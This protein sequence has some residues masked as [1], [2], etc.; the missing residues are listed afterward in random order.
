[1]NPLLLAVVGN[2]GRNEA[3]GG[4]ITTFTKD[5]N[6]WRRHTFTAS[7]TLTVLA[8]FK[9]WTVF[10]VAAGGQGGSGF[11]AEIGYSGYPGG[12][13]GGFEKIV[14]PAAVTTGANTITVGVGKTT[15]DGFGGNSVALGLTVGGGAKGGFTGCPGNAFVSTPTNGN[16]GSEGGTSNGGVGGGCTTP[17]T[18]PAASL[19]TARGLATT[20]G[21]GGA[22]TGQDSG[23]APGAIGGTGIVIVEYQI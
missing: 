15:G 16:T 4:T 6:T 1:M 12:G 22:G 11:I 18:S 23:G 9:P 19:L 14:A 20:I 2:G 5:G 17:S 10:A 7:G 8:S 21:A 13:G 3:T